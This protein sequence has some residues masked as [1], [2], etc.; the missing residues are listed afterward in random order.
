MFLVFDKVYNVPSRLESYISNVRGEIVYKS[1]DENDINDLFIGPHV[2]RMDKKDLPNHEEIFG[3]VLLVVGISS[4][5]EAIQ[6]VNS[7]EKCLSLYMFTDNQE[8]INRV[9]K[10]TSSGALTINDMVKHFAGKSMFT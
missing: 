4:F 10:E 5:D 2:V 3:P 1:L 8:K 9:V 6:I 7:N